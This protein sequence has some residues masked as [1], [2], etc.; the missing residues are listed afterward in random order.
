M[1][2]DVKMDDRLYKKIHNLFAGQ[3]MCLKDWKKKG[4]DGLDMCPSDLWSGALMEGVI[5]YLQQTK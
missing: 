2:E 3:L 5:V 4:L 1:D